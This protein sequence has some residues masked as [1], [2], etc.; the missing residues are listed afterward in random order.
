MIPLSAKIT[1]LK[2]S[3]PK[4]DKKKKKEVQAEVE[5]LEKELKDRHQK[6]IDELESSLK[7]TKMDENPFNSSTKLEEEEKE[8]QKAK[9]LTKTQK[10]RVC[11]AFTDF[12]LE[13]GAIFRRKRRRRNEN[14]PWLSSW[15]KRALQQVVAPLRQKKSKRF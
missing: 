7:A 14:R 10:Q 6:E 3:I 9:K 1:G 2:H 15:T 5:S 11:K 4:N 13:L 12:L 8:S